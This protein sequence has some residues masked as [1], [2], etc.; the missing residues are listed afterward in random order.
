MR[1]NIPNCV[2]V[3]TKMYTAPTSQEEEMSK[4]RELESQEER[5][6]ETSQFSE[7]GSDGAG[8]VV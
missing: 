3:T 4:R 5:P 7:V 2:K 6:E 1:N 8:G